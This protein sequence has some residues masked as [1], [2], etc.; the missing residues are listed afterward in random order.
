MRSLARIRWL[1][2]HG[3]SRHHRIGAATGAGGGSSRRMVTSRRSCVSPFLR[4]CDGIRRGVS[5]AVLRESRTGSPVCF[6][7]PECSR[8]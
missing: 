5:D 4:L 1:R 8:L 7:Q 6:S 2:F 3:R